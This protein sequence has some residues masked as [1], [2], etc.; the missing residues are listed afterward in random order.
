MQ[1]LRRALT[2][3]AALRPT[4]RQLLATPLSPSTPS[5]SSPA[6]PAYSPSSPAAATTTPN[7]PV[8]SA[9]ENGGQS[10]TVHGWVRSI[11]K[12]K[13]VAFAALTD[14][15]CAEGMQAVL[16]PELAKPC[17][18]VLFH[19]ASFLL[20][21]LLALDSAILHVCRNGWCEVRY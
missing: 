2:T 15:S 13:R 12:Q 11:R 9:D 10:L 18:T 4:I 7:V 8:Q 5:S 3:S 16:S 19:L 1:L 17:V 20:L 14:G 6:H 21:R